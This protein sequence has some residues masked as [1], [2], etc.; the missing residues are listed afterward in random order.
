MRPRVDH[1]ELTVQDL[2]RAE[3]FYDALLPLLGFRLEWKS[4]EDVP[5]RE[6]IEIDYPTSDF[7]LGLVC[8]RPALAGDAVCR[9]RPGALHH[10]AFGTGNREEVDQLYRAVRALPG[11]RIRIPPRFYPEYAAGYYA[12]FFYD[13]EGIELEIVHFDRPS[14]FP[15]QED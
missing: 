5:E 9:R 2:D 13:T 14:Y 3:A 8:P 6:Y 1:V 10:L 11:V 4:R 7:S 12:F 15:P